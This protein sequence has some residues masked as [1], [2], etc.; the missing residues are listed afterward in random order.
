MIKRASY[1]GMDWL[2]ALE[3]RDKPKDPSNDL[4]K[5]NESEIK[6]ALASSA[7]V[8]FNLPV[9]AETKNQAL[10]RASKEIADQA[11][12]HLKMAEV[13]G[14]RT[15]IANN[16]IDPIALGV[17]IRENGTERPI[18]KAEW[19]GATDARW[20]EKIATSAALAYEKQVKRAWEQ[21]ALKPAQQLSS[22]FDP[23]TMRDG[24]IMSSTGANEET[25]GYNHQIPANAAS[26]FDPFKL[27]RFAAAENEHDKS[28]AN[29][30]GGHQARDEAK[31]AELQPQ[32]LGPDPMK[33][34][35]VIRSGGQDADV[36]VQRVPKN[37][38]SMVDMVGT[39]KLTPKE[40]QEKLSSL[41]MARIV[42]NGEKI[43]EANKEHKEKIQGTKE[44]DRSWEKLE[45]PLSTA[46][47]Q[48]RLTESFFT[49]PPKPD[50]Q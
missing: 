37:Q 26:I 10:I 27:D 42:D 46:Q 23:A 31:K 24:R 21:N 15:K 40:I 14:I 3:A 33:G 9:N 2:K 35:Q 4:N 36:F 41:F 30:R 50:G 20:V 43:K 29:I 38:L 18:T 48:Q 12:Q 19:E 32:D 25:R 1:S 5:Q 13:N 34:G 22:K 44:S 47:L 17:T 11:A 39:E 7:N 28:V 6:D 16:G 8:A 49:C 45:K